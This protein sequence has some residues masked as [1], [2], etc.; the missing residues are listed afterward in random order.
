MQSPDAHL[1]RWRR[2]PP[3]ESSERALRWWTVSRAHRPALPVSLAHRPR[4]SAAAFVFLLQ[5]VRR[6]YFQAWPPAVWR[7][8]HRGI[9]LD[10]TTQSRA[11]TLVRQCDDRLARLWNFGESVDF[12]R[13]RRTGSQRS[14]AVFVEHRAHTSIGRAR[15]HHIAA[16]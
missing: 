7:V 8:S 14:L 4:R 13:N 10:G 12:D 6:T 5:H 2:R 1:I 11:L 3:S 9:C 16:F 15:E